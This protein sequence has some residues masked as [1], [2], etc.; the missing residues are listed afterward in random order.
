[1]KAFRILVVEDDTLVGVLVGRMLEEMGYDVCAIEAT[2][3]DAVTAAAQYR[4]DLMIVDAWLDDGSGISA[5]EEILRTGFVPHVFMSGNISGV[6]ALRPGAVLLQK[7]FREAELT[8]AI[9][10]ALDAAATF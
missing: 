5:I 6:E 7:P 3:A 1:M 8:R 10:R 2:K 4:P 9:Q